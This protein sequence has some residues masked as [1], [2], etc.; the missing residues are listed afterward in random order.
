M[1]GFLQR[2]ATSASRPQR[3]V[4]PL[5]DAMFAGKRWE[6]TPLPLEAANLIESPAIVA[7]IST[8]ADGRG[9]AEGAPP[10][11]QRSVHGEPSGYSEKRPAQNESQNEPKAIQP[12][13]AHEAAQ[14]D[15][16]VEREKA[17]HEFWSENAKL[18][19]LLS[20]ANTRREQNEEDAAEAEKPK[21]GG[22]ADDIADVERGSRTDLSKIP[23]RARRRERMAHN[24][25]TQV[26]TPPI[27]DIEIHIG[28]IE[29]IAV[30][31]PSSRVVTQ[32]KSKAMS[33]DEYLGRAR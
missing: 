21:E 16:P 1:S 2:I 15:P 6:E 23:G 14:V 22:T 26:Q 28:R 17:S 12:P 8:V 33:L 20:A 32:P 31:P 10:R 11:A 18:P 29:V 27:P 4:H 19:Q 25:S 7:E 3:N 9:A 5:V 13:V 30:P 24:P